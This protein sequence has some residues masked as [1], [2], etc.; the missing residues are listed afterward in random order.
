MLEFIINQ[1]NI[2]IKEII[3]KDK[4]LRFKIKDILKYKNCLEILNKIK[5][6][7]QKK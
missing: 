6:L 1:L 4:V 5:S 2:G 3:K 7:K